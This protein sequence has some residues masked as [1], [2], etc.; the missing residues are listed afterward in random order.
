MRKICR[1]TRNYCKFVYFESAILTPN[2]KSDQTTTATSVLCLQFKRTSDGRKN[3]HKKSY[4][5][6]EK[7]FNVRPLEMRIVCDSCDK[8]PAESEALGSHR[9]AG[10]HQ[11]HLGRPFEERG[12][13]NSG[14]VANVVAYG[15]LIIRFEA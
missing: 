9:L 7:R 14:E 12:A 13:G 4:L 11:L 8:V 10:R 2:W 15:E 3:V 5:V 6:G 1:E